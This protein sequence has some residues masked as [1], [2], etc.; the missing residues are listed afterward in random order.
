MSETDKVSE[1][2]I[3]EFVTSQI[4][5]REQ[6]AINAFKLFLQ[7]FSAIVG[8]SIWLSIQSSTSQ[9]SRPGFAAISDALVGLVF[10]VTAI[11]VAENFRGWLGYRKAQSKMAGEY[12][13]GRLRVPTKNLP[14]GDSRGG[15]RSLHG[16]REWPV[17]VVQSIFAQGK[18]GH[19]HR[20]LRL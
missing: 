2:K 9:A 15:P 7:V 19:Y 11:M 1:D 16:H 6:G 12:P 14:A 5:F 17:R 4:Q 8:G 10:A 20:S 13:D 3:Y 18:L